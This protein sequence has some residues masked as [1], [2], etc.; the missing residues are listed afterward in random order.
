MLLFRL[1]EQGILLC[2][3]HTLVQDNFF[4]LCDDF[5]KLGNDLL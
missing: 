5:I 1:C 3:L 4:L 2:K